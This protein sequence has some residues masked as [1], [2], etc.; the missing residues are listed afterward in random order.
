[1][2]TTDL[3]TIALVQMGVVPGRPDRN[4]ASMLGFIDDAR[5]AGAEVVAFSEMYCHPCGSAVSR[6]RVSTS[7]VLQ[8]P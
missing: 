7:A 6:T 3:P 5:K 4:V 1:M 8:T 2:V